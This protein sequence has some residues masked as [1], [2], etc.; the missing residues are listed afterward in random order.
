MGMHRGSA[1]GSVRP[2]RQSPL[3]LAGLRV[4]FLAQAEVEELHL[5]VPWYRLQE[6]G[7][8]C[9]VV[10]DDE[11]KTYAGAHGLAVAVDEASWAVD[12]DTFAG[13]VVPGGFAPDYVRRTPSSRS[14]V[15]YGYL[16]G[17]VV[18][19]IERGAWVLISAGIL[20]NRTVAAPAALWDDLRNAG[21]RVADEDV[22]VDGNLITARDTAALPAFCRA[23]VAA[24]EKAAAASSARRPRGPRAP[25]GG[26]GQWRG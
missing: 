6:A 9:L 4:G 19:A 16:R 5:W 23:L 7:A 21:A 22:V 24:L 2:R 10:A 12:P 15:R 17:K 3:P 18:A 8:A 20:R 1:A 11:P 14:I 13:F 25:R 26:P